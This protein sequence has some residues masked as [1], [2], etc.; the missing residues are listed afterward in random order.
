MSNTKDSILISL[1][2][3]MTER[4]TQD[5]NIHVKISNESVERAEND[6]MCRIKIAEESA[7]RAEENSK[8]SIRIS[9]SEVKESAENSKLHLKILELED[10]INKLSFG[11]K[12]EKEEMKEE[13]F[14]EDEEFDEEFDE[15]MPEIPGIPTFDTTSGDSSDENN[16]LN[17]NIHITTFDPPGTNKKNKRVKIWTNGKLCISVTPNGPAVGM[18]IKAQ[19]PNCGNC[20]G[21]PVNGCVLAKPLSILMFFA[22]IAAIAYDIQPGEN[23]GVNAYLTRVSSAKNIDFINETERYF[24]IVVDELEE[25]FTDFFEGYA[26]FWEKVVNQGIDKLLSTSASAAEGFSEAYEILEVQDSANSILNKVISVGDTIVNSFSDPSLYKNEKK[27][28]EEAKKIGNSIWNTI[29]R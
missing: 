27:A 12:E 17:A 22:R 6:A 2:Q 21:A 28:Y 3:E 5:N 29:S 10:K 15:E 19:F 20:N 9:D 14:E 23:E 13:K 11:I 16:N 8:L 4:K 18:F 25:R 26:A 1:D 7:K 24:N